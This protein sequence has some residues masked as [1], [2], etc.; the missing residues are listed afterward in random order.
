VGVFKSSVIR[1]YM[2][3]FAQIHAQGPNA[4]LWQRWRRRDLQTF[5]LS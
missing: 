4:P 1:V 5:H 3:T 2:L